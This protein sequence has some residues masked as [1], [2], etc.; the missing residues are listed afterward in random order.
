[1]ASHTLK[2]LDEETGAVILD[3]IDLSSDEIIM[4]SEDNLDINPGTTTG[5]NS[6]HVTQ[7]GAW[8]C[9]GK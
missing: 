3:I 7:T 5:L 8:Q 9:R 1:M 4:F 2:T 6:I